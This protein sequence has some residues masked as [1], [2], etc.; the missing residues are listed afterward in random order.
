MGLHAQKVLMRPPPLSSRHHHVAAPPPSRR[1]SGGSATDTG[2]EG[3]SAG[4]PRHR[5]RC[6]ILLLRWHCRWGAAVFASAPRTPRGRAAGRRH[7]PL[8]SPVT[9]QSS[10]LPRAASPLPPRRE[11]SALL[12]GHCRGIVLLLLLL[13]VWGQLNVLAWVRD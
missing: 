5:F 12:H 10:S 13:S 9:R 8:P 4:L 2:S 7:R 6:P 1:E 11:E 3:T